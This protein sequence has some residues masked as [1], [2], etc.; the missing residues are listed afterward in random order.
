MDFLKK[1]ETLCQ[2]L[3]SAKA[4]YST[5]AGPTAVSTNLADFIKLGTVDFQKFKLP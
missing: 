2:D 4:Q 1:F 3:A 5:P